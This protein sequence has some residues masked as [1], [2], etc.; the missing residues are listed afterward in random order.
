MADITDSDLEKQRTRVDKLRDQVAAEQAKIT[1]GSTNLHNE[2]EM[3]LL[4]AEEARLEAELAAA[5]EA[6]TKAAQREGASVP[7]AQAKQQ[8]EEAALRQRAEQQAA[9]EAEA[10]AAAEE[11]AA[12]ADEQAAQ[13]GTEK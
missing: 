3:T 1:A 9:R 2:V 4:Q 5:K 13:A 12:Q 11:K 6:S 8:M 7:L 10:K